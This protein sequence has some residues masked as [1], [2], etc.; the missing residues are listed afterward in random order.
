MRKKTQLLISAIFVGLFS[1]AMNVQ[2]ET[3]QSLVNEPGRRIEI[4]TGG[5]V[6]EGSK[7]TVSSK[8]SLDTPLD[9]LRS[10]SKYQVIET[11]TKYD[12]EAKTG[13]LIKRA[14]R[15]GND[16]LVR[17][18]DGKGKQ[19]IPVRSGTVDERLMLEV[20]KMPEVKAEAA[21]DKKSPKGGDAHGGAAPAK[22]AGAHD[23]AAATGGKSSKKRKK[24]MEHVHW[25]YT[26][27]GGPDKWADL[28]PANR[29][30]REGQ[31]QS[32]I[33]I[34]K[35]MRAD[36]TPV[37]FNYGPAGFQII[38][39][40]HTI[41]ALVPGNVM[42]LNGKAYQLLH[43]HFH[44]PS[45]ERVDGRA[46]AMVAHLVHKAA[47]GELAVVAVLL[48]EGQDNP[49]IKSFWDAIPL[50]K[51]K[52]VGV[53]SVPVD[54]HQLLPKDQRYYNYM[55]SLTTPPCTEGIVWIVMKEPVSISAEQIDTF[56]RFYSNNSRPIQQPSGRL[57]KESR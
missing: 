27:E 32:P 35:G 54:L 33:N 36:L 34:E 42:S 29:L 10:N 23:G 47:D 45:E 51:N 46:Y 7:V 49:V 40:G 14:L 57:I 18:E 43:L 6:R 30:C 3:W 1:T 56:A 17:E 11:T 26:G 24:G 19:D 22:S 21:A 28:D 48:Q 12:C 31:R 2:A 55:G 13:V 8:V 25:A 16:E 20:C 5:V 41:Q 52:L 39:N 4:N 44:R 9:D 37:V 38:D 53:E 50:E 15:K